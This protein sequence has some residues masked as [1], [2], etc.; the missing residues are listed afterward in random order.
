MTFSGA[1]CA[2][3]SGDL[4]GRDT[5]RSAFCKEW[6]HPGPREGNTKSEVQDKSWCI[7]LEVSW[8][9][10]VAARAQIG[11]LTEPITV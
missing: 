8:N 3:G 7:A 4:L 5:R 9:W 6:R 2:E 1:R 10:A 11:G